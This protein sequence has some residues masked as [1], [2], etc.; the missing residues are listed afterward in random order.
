MRVTCCAL[1]MCVMLPM[2]AAAQAWV[3]RADSLIRLGLITRAEAL[4]YAAVR[5]NP[6]DPEARYALGHY[7]ASRGALRVAA[8]LVEEGRRFG[9]D[10]AKAAA[11]LAPIYERLNDYGPLTRLDPAVLAPAE[12]ARARWLQANPPTVAGPD[13]VRLPLVPAG[14]PGVFGGVLMIVAGDTVRAE[15]DPSVQGIVIDRRH[16]RSAAV[17]AF[18]AGGSATQPG[19]ATRLMIGSIL[20]RNV[21]VTLADL[22]GAGIA[23]V[24]L[25]FLAQWAPTFDPARTRTITL[26]RAGRVPPGLAT[27]RTVRM[28][29]L[30]GLPAANGQTVPGTWIGVPGGLARFGAHEV[31]RLLTARVTLDP[32]RGELLVDR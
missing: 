1:L 5:R 17:R 13:S 29:L 8:V 6:R 3:A 20:L 30:H 7:L 27:S 9:G 21:P 15:I 2:T 19:V 22:G 16:S 31:S 10:P 32:R 28:P 4:Y 25:D 18:D 24:G 26:R 23:R 14:R 12:M 11:L